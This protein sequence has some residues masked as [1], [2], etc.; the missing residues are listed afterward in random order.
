MTLEASV[1]LNSGANIQNLR[2]LLHVELLHQF[3]TFSSEVGSATPENFTSIFLGL[4]T[5]F[6]HVNALSNKERVMC[7]GMRKPR[8][9]RVRRCDD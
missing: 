9:L 4:D 2:T 1:T 8:S 5:Y 3:D 7:R 6:S